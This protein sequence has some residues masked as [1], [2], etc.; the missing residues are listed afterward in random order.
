MSEPRIWTPDEV[1]IV[2]AALYGSS[3]QTPL[4][5]AIEADSGRP[6]PQN[7]IAKW[8]MESGGR[9]IP[10][11][12]QPRLTALFIYLYGITEDERQRALEIIAEH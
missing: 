10:E 2:A 6:F 11:W 12:L 7:R 4:A 9:G 1:R 8:Y 3:W 5:K